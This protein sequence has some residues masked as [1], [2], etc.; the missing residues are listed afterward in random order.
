VFPN[1]PGSAIEDDEHYPSHLHGIFRAKRLHEYVK[2]VSALGMRR[3]GGAELES[4]PG[5]DRIK[6]EESN[7]ATHHVEVRPFAI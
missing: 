6:M 1:P 7:D 5:L 4:M 3:N 2:E